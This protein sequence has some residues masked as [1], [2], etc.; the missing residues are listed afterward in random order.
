M[1]DDMKLYN[2]LMYTSDRNYIEPRNSLRE[3]IFIRNAHAHREV[4]EFSGKF[5]LA[6]L[7]LQSSNIQS[8]IHVRR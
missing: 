7:M 8:Y 4:W 6:S 3:T 2:T 5:E 1:R